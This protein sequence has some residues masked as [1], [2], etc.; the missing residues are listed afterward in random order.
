MTDCPRP[1][2]RLQL[3][4]F[5]GLVNFY[6]RFIPKAVMILRPLKHSLVGQ[7]PSLQWTVEMESAFLQ[8]KKALESAYILVHPRPSASLALAVD[9]SATHVGGALS[10]AGPKRLLYIKDH[11]QNET[12]HNVLRL[13]FI[14]NKGS[15]IN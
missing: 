4:R 14:K 1:S 9:A 10:P 5:L 11:T 3:Q 13:D 15:L 7:S 2:D 12:N 8:V 6:R